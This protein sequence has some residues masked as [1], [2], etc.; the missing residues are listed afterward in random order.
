MSARVGPHSSS[1]VP[2][3]WSTERQGEYGSMGC[4][5]DTMT[6]S[7]RLAKLCGWF[8]ANRDDQ[9]GACSLTDQRRRR[10]GVGP[11]FRD[12]RYLRRFP[13]LW[14]LAFLLRGSDPAIS[15][16]NG[17]VVVQSVCQADQRSRHDLLTRRSPPTRLTPRQRDRGKETASTAW[18]ASRG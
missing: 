10:D 6:P 5:Q 16:R 9:P 7:R 3:V 17:F 14:L 4:D 1:S 8:G 12:L 11:N 13:S 18:L 2:T 15:T